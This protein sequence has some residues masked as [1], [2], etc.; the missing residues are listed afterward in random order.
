M[1]HPQIETEHETYFREKIENFFFFCESKR[2][3]PSLFFI[4]TLFNQWA[5]AK[6]LSL[7]F[8]LIIVWF[9]RFSKVGVLNKFAGEREREIGRERKKTICFDRLKSRIL[10]S[11]K[12]TSQLFRLRL[13]DC[14]RL[15]QS[16]VPRVERTLEFPRWR[17]H[18]FPPSNL[19]YFGT[20]HDTFC[21]CCCLISSAVILAK[22]KRLD[23]SQPS[24]AS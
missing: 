7:R 9:W 22:G 10:S 12:S 2:C 8:S 20:L 5:D 19:S 16:S 18:F 3:V 11:R 6:S 1:A 13:G 17:P 15:L 21:C 4:S 23:P 24:P 14:M